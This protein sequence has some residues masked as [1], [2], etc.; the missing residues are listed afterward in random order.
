MLR[1][2]FNPRICIGND[3]HKN[4]NFYTDH[5]F[6]TNVPNTVYAGSC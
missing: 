6:N 5:A 2:E 3:I 4:C 1:L